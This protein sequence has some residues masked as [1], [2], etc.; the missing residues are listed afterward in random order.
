R[1]RRHPRAR[2]LVRSLSAMA[3]IDPRHAYVRFYLSVLEQLEQVRG[4][5]EKTA[6]ETRAAVTPFTAVLAV[7]DDPDLKR[8]LDPPFGALAPTGL[9]RPEDPTL[10][11]GRSQRAERRIE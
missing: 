3:S 6:L 2:R 4:V 11:P 8:V 9:W 10:Q 5:L 7:G 1:T